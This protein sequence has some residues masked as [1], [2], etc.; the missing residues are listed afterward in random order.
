MTSC[1]IFVVLS[2]N[3]SAIQSFYKHGMIMKLGLVHSYRWA[4]FVWWKSYLQSKVSLIISNEYVEIS[5]HSKT[6]ISKHAV[7][8]AVCRF[9]HIQLN[10]KSRCVELPSRSFLNIY[11]HEICFL[12]CPIVMAQR[13]TPKSQCLCAYGNCFAL[14]EYKRVGARR[15]LSCI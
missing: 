5:I 11:T 2:S 1:W 13:P 12:L 14:L 9:Y 10:N 3:S 15:I 4:L 8:L 7:T 6:Y